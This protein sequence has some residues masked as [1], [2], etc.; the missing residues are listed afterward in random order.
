M[1]YDNELD[2]LIEQ[3]DQ[4]DKNILKLLAKRFELTEKVGIYKKNH[5]LPSCS[6][7]RE[8]LLFKEIK[9]LAEELNL[10]TKL[11]KDIFE[12]ILARVKENHE[13]IKTSD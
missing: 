5:D 9:K 10:D 8:T 2:E 3:I 1:Q 7:D 6:E 12:L 11:V 13:H 4:V